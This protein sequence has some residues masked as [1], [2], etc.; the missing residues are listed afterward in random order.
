MDASK[1]PD[2]L[3]TQPLEF[4]MGGLD[5]AADA[6]L[7]DDA[8]DGHLG[9]ESVAEVSIAAEGSNAESEEER[10]SH[11]TLH[12]EESDPGASREPTVLDLNYVAAIV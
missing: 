3:E 8:Q 11:H 4:H 10:E 1:G 6:K 2:N 12:Y 5:V 7:D 9:T